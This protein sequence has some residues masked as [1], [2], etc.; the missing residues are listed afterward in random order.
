M[1]LGSAQLETPLAPPPTLAGGTGRTSGSSACC[2]EPAATSP[3]DVY[4]ERAVFQ[5]HPP[6]FPLPVEP[7]YLRS[8]VRMRRLGAWHHTCLSQ[9]ICPDQGNSC[10]MRIWSKLCTLC[11]EPG[12]YLCTCLHRIQGSLL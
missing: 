6:S 11:S 12:T 9:S 8:G 10:P 4:G 3:R 7:S 5:Q 2:E 1:V